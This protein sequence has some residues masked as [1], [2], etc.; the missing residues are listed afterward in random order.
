MSNQ[1]IP[2]VGPPATCFVIEREQW[3]TSLG[4]PIFFAAGP[5]HSSARQDPTGST[6]LSA[7]DDAWQWLIDGSAPSLKCH[8]RHQVRRRP[9]AW[10]DSPFALAS[11]SAIVVR[12]GEKPHHNLLNIGSVANVT[13]KGRGYFSALGSPRSK[14]HD[15]RLL[16]H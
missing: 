4:V 7:T 14:P 16:F 13:S 8:Q 10:T 1:A 5:R 15:A 9:R 12:R 2:R 11:R 3:Y 6:T